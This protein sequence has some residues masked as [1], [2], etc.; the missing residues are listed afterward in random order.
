VPRRAPRSAFWHA[1]RQRSSRCGAHVASSSRVT[2]SITTALERLTAGAASVIHCAGAIAAPPGR[3]V[4]IGQCRR[5]PA[6]RRGRASGRNSS[7]RA[8]LVPGGAR[9]RAVGLRL[10]QAAGRARGHG[11]ARQRPLGDRAPAGGLRA[12]RRG[13]PAAHGPTHP[14]HRLAARVPPTALF[15]ALRRRSGPCLDPACRNAR[16]A[17]QSTNCTT[18][19]PRAMPGPTLPR[20]PQVLQGRPV[21]CATCRAWCSPACRACRSAG[22]GPP[23]TGSGPKSPPAR[24]ASFT[25]ATGCAGTICSTRRRP[26]APR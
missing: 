9:A 13:D 11:W 5:D 16:R 21:G 18:A 2:F 15:A 25:I 24:C 4:C 22:H 3:H 10:E 6:P 23:V 14:A 1:A 19:G 7:L 12:G 20:P 26:G 17:A 8:C